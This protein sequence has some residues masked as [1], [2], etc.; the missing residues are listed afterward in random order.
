MS[1][2]RFGYSVALVALLTASV[3]HAQTIVAPPTIILTNYDRV[4]VGQREG[5][6]AGAYVARTDDAAATWF[7]PAGLGKSENSALNASANAYDRTSIN[8]AG[9]GAS[10]GRSNIST[11]AT[12]F[13]FVIGGDVLRSNRWRLGF[14]VT[15]P[16]GW[17][18][19]NLNLTIP[20]DSGRERVAYS[21]AVSLSVTRPEL[22]VAFT[23]GGVSRGKLRFGGRMGFAVTS[24]SQAVGL[25]DR[26]TTTDSAVSALQGFLGGGSAWSLLFTGGVQWDATPHLSVGA[27]LVAPSIALFGSSQLAYQNSI[28]GVGEYRDLVFRD[29]SGS[30]EYRQP[31]ELTAG[32][33]L[34]QH[35]HEL[36]FDL[37][38]YAAISPYDLYASTVPGTLTTQVPGGP[39]TVTQVPF[40][41]TM[42]SARAIVNVAVGGNYQ[43]SRGFRLH[44]GVSTDQSP[45]DVDSLS[46][47]RKVNLSHITAGLSLTG[48]KG[49]SGSVG[50]AYSFGSNTRNTIGLPEGG[51]GTA[52]KLTVKTLNVMFAFSFAFGASGGTPPSSGR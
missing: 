2:P 25:S 14:S 4:P 41:P 9:L 22:G 1:G 16:I 19:S 40:A 8:L 26:L 47:F 21:T 28:Y 42:N 18:P 46:V 35:D 15:Q 6:E 43:V 3:V 17:Q 13:G 48:V 51:Q 27:R 20:L 39:T 7:N 45:V 5:L 12:L 31:F 38:Y 34:K 44:A 52:T 36:E 29:S 33:A 10:T 30:F 49:L 11:I 50:F 24:L 32:A 37:H 23:P